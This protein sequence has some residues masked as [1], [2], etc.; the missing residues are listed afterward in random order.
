MSWMKNACDFFV[1][2]VLRSRRMEKNKER[3]AD[4]ND[5]DE[6]STVTLRTY[7]EGGDPFHD[8]IEFHLTNRSGVPQGFREPK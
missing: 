6:S 4:C 5:S 2:H 8:R 7:T 1:R 3:G